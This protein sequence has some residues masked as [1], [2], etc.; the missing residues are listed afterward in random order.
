MAINKISVIVPARN[1]E[2]YLPSCLSSVQRAAGQI[3]VPVEMVVVLNRCSDGTEAVA[4]RFGAM[5]IR[6]DQ[7]N[8]SR[9]R[10]AGVRA[11]SGDVVVTM[12][13]DSWMSDNMLQAV[14]RLL[15]TGRFVGGGVRIKAERMSLGILLSVMTF[16][17]RLLATGISAG[18]FWLRRGDFDAIGGFDE[19]L[20]SA[21]D[22][23]FARR[24]KSYGRVRGLRFGMIV[25]AH[26]VTSCRKFD[27]FGDWYLVKNRQMVKRILSGRDEEAA[28]QIYYDIER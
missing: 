5:I 24:L 23:D 6:E 13:A 2:R 15:D 18:L 27:H 17:P 20:V 4:R 1:E 3:A 28:N 12:D 25:R 8:L 7:R 22:V 9:I 21:E 26:I 10:N 19:R 11:S 16:A 14:V